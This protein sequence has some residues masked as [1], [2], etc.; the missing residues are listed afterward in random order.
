M[1]KVYWRGRYVL[2]AVA[3]DDSLHS[4]RDFDDLGPAL[5]VMRR[6]GVPAELHSTSR[7][8]LV[9]FWCPWHRTIRAGYGATESERYE[10][11]AF[12]AF[13]WILKPVTA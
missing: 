8:Q 3:E 7:R 10:L 1:A 9:A 13:H 12:L 6:A 4:P 11:A 2:Y 5:D